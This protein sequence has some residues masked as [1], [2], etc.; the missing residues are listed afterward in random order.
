M[1]RA[2]PFSFTKAGLWRCRSVLCMRRNAVLVAFML[3][4]ALFVSC[5][6]SVPQ[7]QSVTPVVV[8]DFSDGA[9]SM[10]LSVFAE[11]SSD[12]QRVKEVRAIHKDSGLVWICREPQ[13]FSANNAGRKWAGCTNFVAAS[14]SYIP[15]GEYT[16]WY[17]DAAERETEDSFSVFYPEN[18]LSC[19]AESIP[20]AF[21]ES[22]KQY[23]A[24][25]NSDGVLIFYGE[26]KRE[27]K[28][29]GDVTKKYA[30]AV[31]FRVC[32]ELNGGTVECLMP[33]VELSETARD[34]AIEYVPKN[35]R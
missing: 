1:N 21:T 27:W 28:T 4:G 2:V 31:T 24:L 16:L 8:F 30:A 13:K 26:R 6:D 29:L 20:E 35:T 15:Q 12:V 32:Y 3:V 25:Y 33:A 23:I 11:V 18:L 14:G 22:Y 7:L 19:K 17:E 10:R 34:F 9:P 5:A